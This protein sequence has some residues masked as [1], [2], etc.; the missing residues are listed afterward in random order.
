MTKAKQSKP[1]SP[2]IQIFR[3]GQLSQDED[4]KLCE[5]MTSTEP[6][7]TFSPVASLL[8]ATLYQG[9]HDRNHKF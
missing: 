6:L 1:R 2:R 8:V 9:Y 5:T 7:R 4:R 3:N